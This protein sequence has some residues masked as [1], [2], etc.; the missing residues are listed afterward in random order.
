MLIKYKAD[1]NAKNHH[2]DTALSLAASS[3]KLNS[4]RVLIE[5]GA[6]VNNVSIYGLTPILHAEENGYADIVSEL[7]KAGAKG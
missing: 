6:N 7:Q 1:V 3:G 2:G 5:S 4:V